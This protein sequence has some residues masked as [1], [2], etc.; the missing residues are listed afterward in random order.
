MSAAAILTTEE[1]PTD[2]P[3]PTDPPQ[4][5]PAD[6]VIP[7]AD[8]TDPPTD[9]EKPT[10]APESYADFTLPEGL[11]LDAEALAE[12]APFAK[13]LNLPQE[14]AQKIV[15]MG[16][17]L[18]QKTIDG[19]MSAHRERVGTWLKEAEAD[20]EIGA[21]IKLGAES[22]TLR[23]FN[24]VTQG[25]EKAKAMV[26]ELGIGNHPEFLRIFFKISQQ[27]REDTFVVPGSGGK[28]SP[29]E[30]MYP[31]MRK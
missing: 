11:S 31:T 22:A 30:T 18:V 29:A 1:P 20:P 10:G 4:D 3:P 23:A 16:G 9:G 24:T 17:K 25:D 12:F 27:M 13:E 7:P 15:E 8:P 26:E 28:G 14:Q 5:P 6:P 21:D 19:M 2:T